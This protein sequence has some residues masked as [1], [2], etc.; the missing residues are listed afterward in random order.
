MRR[1]SRPHC[2][3]RRRERRT[4]LFAPFCF[5]PIVERGE[6]DPSSHASKERHETSL[7]SLGSPSPP[8]FPRVGVDVDVDCRKGAPTHEWAWKERR[9]MDD[10]MPMAR[11][12]QG[13]ETVAES[14]GST[15]DE[16]KVRTKPGEQRDHRRTG[17]HANCGRVPRRNHHRRQRRALQ[18]LRPSCPRSG[19]TNP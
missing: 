7:R 15:I 11:G 19:R 12:E 17:K 13:K 9:W 14:G 8:A 4:H 10:W 2:T 5:V 16:P 3:M 18:R 6:T 1:R